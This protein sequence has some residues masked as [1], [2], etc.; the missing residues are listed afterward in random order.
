[1]M[2]SISAKD[3]IPHVRIMNIRTSIS[4]KIKPNFVVSLIG[5][6]FGGIAYYVIYSFVIWLG[7]DTD[8][9]KMLSALVVAIFLAVPYLK[10]RYFAKKPTIEEISGGDINA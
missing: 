7:L 4:M 6:T 8:L 9:L 5:V 10:G 1:M 2:S 3:V